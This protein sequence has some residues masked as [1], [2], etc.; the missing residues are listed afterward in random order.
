MSNNDGIVI[1]IT[2]DKRLQILRDYFPTAV[3]TG[4][5][6][7]FISE[8]SR[9]EL[10]ERS[11]GGLSGPDEVSIIRVRLFARNALGE[12]E[13]GHYEDFELADIHDLAGE[14]EKFVQNA[15]GRNL[16]E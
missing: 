5:A 8:D 3:F 16:K 2:M 6:L 1:L 13:P 15:V 12:F 9:V 11:R 4:N 10:T 14:I 7:V